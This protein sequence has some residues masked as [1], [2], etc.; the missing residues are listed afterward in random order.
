MGNRSGRARS[1]E[2]M[3]KTLAV[4]AKTPGVKKVVNYGHVR[5]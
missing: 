4:I 3:K 2:E 5:P 1:Q